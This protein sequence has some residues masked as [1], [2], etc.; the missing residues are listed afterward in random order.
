MFDEWG[1]LLKEG[2][3]AAV[4]SFVYQ[5]IPTI[6]FAVM[7]GGSLLALLTGSDAGAGLGLLGLIGGVF[8]W[9]VL[10]IIFGFIG[11]AGVANYAREGTLGAGFDFGVITTVITSRDYIVAWLYVIA[12]NIVV[13]F[14]SGAL[15]IIPGLGGLIGV[16]L[17]FYALI[18]VGWLWGDGFAAAMG[19]RSTTSVD[20]ET[21]PA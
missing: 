2:V 12:L 9:W 11:F 15:N 14:V 5:L 21:V 16:F 3:V 17:G 7:V 20:D 6:V 4:I 13:G 8:V 18:I 19:T 10:A 1:E